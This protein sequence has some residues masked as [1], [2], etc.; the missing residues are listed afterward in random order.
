MSNCRSNDPSS[1]QKHDNLD[2]EI[3]FF[4]CLVAESPD[5]VE[6]LIPLADAYTKKGMYQKGLDT[7][8]KIS[9]LRP[10][11][12]LVLY[13]LA[14]SYALLGRIPQALCSMEKALFLGYRDLKQ[15]EG[16]ADLE[17]LRKDPRLREML[18]RF[19]L[20]KVDPEGSPGKPSNQI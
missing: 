3:E 1:R 8:E 10:A 13:N 20:P 4:E 9:R 18:M 19:F 12:P 15:I 2:F 17:N 16:D 5:F 14:C 11:D 7:D 6:A